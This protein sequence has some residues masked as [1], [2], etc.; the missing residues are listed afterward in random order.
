MIIPRTTQI[1]RIMSALEH[2]P[3]VAI[4][5]AR[6]VGKTTITYDI[7]AMWGTQIHRFDLEDPEDLARLNEPKLA[8]QN[9]E[10][11]IIID[12][13]QRKP[14]LFPLLRVLVDRRDNPAQFLILGSASPNLLKQSSESL[15]GRVS[16]HT[17]NGFSLDEVVAEDPNKL[18]I[19]G[20]FPRSYLASSDK[21]SLSW[22]KDFIR[23]FLERDIPQLGFSIPARTLSRFWN[24]LAHY[25]AQT[26]NAS[27]LARAFGMSHASVKRYL[28]LLTDSLVVW[29]LKPWYQNMGKR[30]VKAPKVYVKDSGILHSLLGVGSY[31]ELERHPKI[32]ASWEGFV[33]GE[34]LHHLEVEPDDAYYWATHAG[35]E[36]DLLVFLAG[37]PIGF[38]V[39]RSVKP[40]LTPSM[41]TSL[42]DLNLA[43]LFVIHAGEHEF[44]MHDKITALPLSNI[45]LT[46]EWFR[47]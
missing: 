43:H 30:Q 13:I 18:W 16:Y 33:L 28:D 31:V 11:L 34:L 41:R 37:R 25:H 45:T 17:L 38:E 24:M 3:I 7:E 10:G 1:S 35:A 22:R 20:G 44:Q 21:A 6:Q 23:T 5:G 47:Q 26:W 4:L 40:K 29:Q 2:N 39:K 9:L 8:L 32:G 46:Q 15:A 19:R 14:D 36:L 12:E 42:T 27:E